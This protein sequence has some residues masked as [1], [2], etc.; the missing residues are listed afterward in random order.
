MSNSNGAVLSKQKSLLPDPFDLHD[1][2]I[3]EKVYLAHT[4]DDN[5]CDK[6]TLY[7]LALSVVS[8]SHQ[9]FETLKLKRVESAVF[10]D[11]RNLKPNFKPDYSSL[12]NISSQMITIPSGYDYLHQTTMRI[13]NLLRTYSWDAKIV[14]ALAAFSLDYGNYWN[15]YP[16]TVTDELGKA[17]KQLNQVQLRQDHLDEVYTLVE[18]V[19]EAVEKI[20]QWGILSSEADD[21][22]DLPALSDA[23]QDIPLV[24]YWAVA[25]LV[26][27]TSNFTGVSKYELPKFSAK[28][29]PAL[30]SLKQHLD[31]CKIQKDE[32]GDYR[33]RKNGIKKPK[34]IVDFL[35]LLIHSNGSQTAQV[36][37]GST[38]TKVTQGVEVFKHKHVLLFLSGLHGVGDEIR[39]LNHIYDRLLEDPKELNGYQKEDFK[40][41]W[42][43]IVDNWDDHNKNVF[44]HHLEHGGIKWYVVEYFAPLPGIR[45]IKEDLKYANKPILPVID[46]QGK[47]INDDAM[48]IV[49]EWG[50]DAFP[51]GKEDGDRIT[52][53]WK[54]FWDE[55]KKANLNIQVKGDR[56]IFIYGGNDSKWTQEFKQAV[57]N[58]KK[59]EETIKRED[60][61]IDA[62]QL[63]KDDPKK[64][65]RFWIGIESKRQTKQFAN[66][67]K[68]IQQVVKS[69]LCLKQDTQGW[70][71][72]TKGAHL[73]VLGHGEPMYQTVANFNEW[74]QNVL[75]KEGFDIAFKE[76]YDSKVKDLPGHQ[77]CAYMK[78][79]NYPSNVIGTITCPNAACG[80]VMEVTS[81]DY[82]CCH[83]DAPDT[84]LKSS[85]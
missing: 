44:K 73:K 63:G 71:L 76:Y 30:D 15:L 8:R 79:D 27:C 84:M 33:S 57:D 47:V 1:S 34:D 39:L 85:T 24:V 54:W 3:L 42:I 65:N 20:Y 9:Y 41:L 43:P 48:H 45:L 28:L 77:P 64:I 32:T 5:E 29:S 55:L 49:F 40:I 36:Y 6:K 68:E 62:Y 59:D 37:D 18:H 17:L 2:D 50:I 12:K 11:T 69:L 22:E 31:H 25:S 51:F 23:L 38:K 78:I 66:L 16:P 10:L 46:P 7:S 52:Q 19:K 83:R 13:L 67:D 53:K 21:T 56:Y 14:I 81:V 4:Y 35:K 82:K 58:I 60:V 26:A 80:R 74:K 61:I 72:L 70:A 75:V